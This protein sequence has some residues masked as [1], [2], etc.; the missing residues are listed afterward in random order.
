LLFCWLRWLCFG[1]SGVLQT[2][3]INPRK[4]AA[5]NFQQQLTNECIKTENNAQQ[6]LR[7]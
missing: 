7:L 3:K 5:A 6:L 4:P 2:S 1:V